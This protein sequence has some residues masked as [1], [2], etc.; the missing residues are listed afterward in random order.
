MLSKT[1]ERAGLAVTRV[2]IGLLWLTRAAWK[3]PPSFGCPPDF[4]ASIDY[5]SGPAVSAIGRASWRR[6]RSSRRWSGL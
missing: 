5:A 2:V 1:W 3:L 6:L 4:A